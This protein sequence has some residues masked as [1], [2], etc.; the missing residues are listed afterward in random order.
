MKNNKT[1]LGLALLFGF[2]LAAALPLTAS[3]ALYRELQ[4][5]MSGSDVSELQAFL[6]TD[7]SI[8]PQ[9]SVTGYFGLLTKAAVARYQSRNA[10][11]PVGRVGPQTLEYILSQMGGTVG[12]VFPWFTGISVIPGNSSATFNIS[13]NTN[14]RAAVH[15]GTSPVP[16][17]ENE[18]QG[19][20]TLGGT[21]A[22][23]SN[24]LQTSH[25]ITTGLLQPN[26]LYYYIAHIV[27]ANGKSSVWF[28]R[29]TTSN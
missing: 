20:V 22:Q 16:A 2:A 10:I 7:T 15:Y 13:A 11:S 14:V 12:T 25:S 29:F 17:S 18:S 4:L 9:G 19:S 5:G 1:V 21:Q 24:T 3:A 28:G 27:N 8:Y 26:T 23:V 6:A